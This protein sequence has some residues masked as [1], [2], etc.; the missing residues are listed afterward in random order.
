MRLSITPSQLCNLPCAFCSQSQFGHRPH[1]SEAVLYDR[2]A[3]VYPATTRMVLLGGEPT[4]IPNLK[5][6]LQYLVG[7]YPHI[8]ISL[9]TDG[10]GL[11]EGW[12]DLLIHSKTRLIVS[13]NAS[14]E[15]AFRALMRRPG[16]ERIWR[17]VLTNVLAYRQR[18]ETLR[19]RHPRLTLSRVVTPESAADV[20]PFA[21]LAAQLGADC[22]FLFDC[23]GPPY[24]QHPAV[25]RS[26]QI[27]SEL[28]RPF[29]PR[30]RAGVRGG[31]V[32]RGAARL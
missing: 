14:N 24:Q 16:G 29:Y 1:L 5:P 30:V 15:R 12:N 31:P 22:K 27:V 19:L 18:P 21:L 26:Y 28:R 32:R 7:N 23:R 6:Y 13:L 11:D 3:A 8:R 10:T 17:K 4:I 25:R 20:E 2:L 9:V